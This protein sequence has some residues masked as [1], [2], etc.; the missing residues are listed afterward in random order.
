MKIELNLSQK[1]IKE[2]KKSQKEN[3]SPQYYKR[4]QIILLNSKGYSNPEIEEILDIHYN[5][6]YKWVKRYQANGI[7]GLKDKPGRGRNSI[8]DEN[9]IEKIEK[10]VN[11]NPRRINSVLPEIITELGKSMSQWTVKRALK[12]NGY[13]YKRARTSLK[14]KQDPEQFKI[15][16]KP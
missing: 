15:K 4:V 7:E 2:L 5:S 14:G 11:K 10:L 13:T 3:K 6:V 1:E 8:I 16:K 9:D 12:N